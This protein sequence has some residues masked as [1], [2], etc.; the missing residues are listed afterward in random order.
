MNRVYLLILWLFFSLTVSGQGKSK[1]QTDSCKAGNM[2][3]EH[4]LDKL[5]VTE[6]PLNEIQKITDR[7]KQENALLAYFR[8]RGNVYHR[9]NRDYKAHSLGNIA[10]KADFELAEDALK[11]IFVG[12]PAYPR[13]FCGDDIDWGTR[14]VPD[15]EWVWQLNRMNFWNAMGRVYWHT[16]EE[17][18]AQAW[19]EQLMDWVNKNPNDEDHRYAWRSIEAGIQGNSWCELYQRFIDSPSFTP[20]VLITFLNSLHDHATFLM[21]KYTTNSNWALME[22][23]GLASIKAS[24]LNLKSHRY[25]GK[26]LSRDSISKSTIRC[27]LTGIRENWPW[28]IM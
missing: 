3:I 2:P 24:S 20:E 8:S 4:L 21:T 6:A 14:P 19:C 11:H 15:N 27:I 10:S 5:D 26:K 16:D 18:Y 22:A 23:E 28:D 17:K 25:G 1:L 9:I 13:F 12:Q 7:E